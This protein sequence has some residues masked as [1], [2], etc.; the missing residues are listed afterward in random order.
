MR[1][2]QSLLSALVT[3]GVIAYIGV[4]VYHFSNGFDV[5]SALGGGLRDVRML[6]ECWRE[7]GA[8]KEFIEREPVLLGKDPVGLSQQLGEFPGYGRLCGE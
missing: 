6:G 4:A 7:W 3:V 1:R 5:P 8:V 2:I